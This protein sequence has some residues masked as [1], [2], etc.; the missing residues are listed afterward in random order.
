MIALRD[1]ILTF[2]FIV[3]GWN[4]RLVWILFIDAKPKT[5]K[6]NKTKTSPKSE[7]K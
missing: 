5:R 3:I 4:L 2:A 7:E 1:V 6:M